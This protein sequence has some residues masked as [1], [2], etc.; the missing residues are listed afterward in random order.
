VSKSAKE[1]G[2]PIEYK[3]QDP[4]IHCFQDMRKHGA[5]PKMEK[6]VPT[7]EDVKTLASS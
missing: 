2:D 6:F 3:G 5:P 4:R 1:G 7:P